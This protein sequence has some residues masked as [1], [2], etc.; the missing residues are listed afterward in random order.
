MQASTKQ[1][2]KR[3]ESL[4]CIAGQ[5]VHQ[6]CRCKYGAP[7]QIA[8]ALR[9]TVK[10]GVGTNTGQQVLRSAERQFNFSPDCFCCGELASNIRKKEKSFRCCSCEDRN[11]THRHRN[12]GG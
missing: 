9:Q 10:Q 6:E 4:Q 7:N 12:H 3:N 2:K 8:K 5:P 11:K 1:V